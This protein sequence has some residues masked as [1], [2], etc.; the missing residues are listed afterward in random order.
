[1]AFGRVIR[2]FVV[3][4]VLA[5]VLAAMLVPG[6]LAAQ[7]GRT[8]GWS[9]VAE[10]TFV[11]TAGN[12][13]SSTFG[14]KNTAD[15]LW[16]K[17]SLKFSAGA[18]RTESG[19]TTRTATGTPDNFTVSEDTET[20]VTAENFFLKSRLDRT[21]G[22]ASFLYG[23]AGWDRNTFAGVQNRY[24]FVSGAGRNWFDEDSRRLKTDLGLTYTIQ[25]DVVENP[26]ADGSFLGLRGSY[27]YFRKLTETTGMTSVLIVDQNL[28]MTEDFRADWTNSIAVAMSERL[29]LKTSLQIL[30]DKDPALTAIPLGGGKVL[31]PLGKVDTVFTVAIVANF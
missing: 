4:G 11:L 2:E 10:L 25:D 6:T 23:G 5:G 31:T 24:G 17:T 13:S 3:A 26:D 22:E 1:M 20:E 9:E 27:D 15:Y 30:Y 16:E 21:V 28:N 18:V 7:D 12:A 29:A 14:F 19:L 8:L